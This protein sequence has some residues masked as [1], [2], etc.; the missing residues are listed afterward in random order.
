[1][2]TLP[3]EELIWYIQD[4]SKTKEIK[5]KKKL[6]VLLMAATLA[7]SAVGCGSTEL[8]N[9]YIT[10]TQYKNLEVPKLP[11][12]EV[13]DDMVEQAIQTELYNNKVS[14]PVTDIAA[15]IGDTVIIDYVGSVDGVEFEGGTANNA[16]LKLGSGTFIGPTDEYS[17][18]EEQ[19]VG[20]NKGDEF[21]IMVQFP[22]QYH[23]EELQGQPANFH[24]VLHDI[25][26]ED[27]PELNDEFVKSVS[28]KSKTV[29]EYRNE[30]KAKL[31]ADNELQSESQKAFM[32]LDSLA[33]KTEI[34]ELPEGMLEERIEKA[35][36]Y[37][38][39]IAQSS[40]LEFADFCLQYLNMDEE[41][42]NKTVREISE[43]AIKKELACN[44]IAEE[45]GLM[46]TEEEF[47]ELMN[48]FAK[49]SGFTSV[50]EFID[51]VGE[52][53]LKSA[54]VQDKVGAYL[55]K[56]CVVVEQNIPAEGAR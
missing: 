21:D 27:M 44:L 25:V 7:F 15:E 24:I 30:I 16:N 46:P 53:E 45:K 2:N 37:Y 56:T 55:A 34:I 26:I 54:I 6:V 19:I 3:R 17:G 12:M 32:V 33:A 28:E 10:V 38:K 41:E 47:D 8:S 31:E 48:Q 29:D 35:D 14:T 23:S 20:H 39:S 49:E 43:D 22:E 13:T 36:E 52:Q 18:F 40:E 42:Y 51:M 1:M 5:M 11:Q 4:I 9:E 50:D